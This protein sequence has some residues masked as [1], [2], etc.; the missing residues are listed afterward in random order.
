[1]PSSR[2]RWT[3]SPA[4]LGIGPRMKRRAFIKLLGGSVAAWPLAAGGQP[5]GKV[6]TVGVLMAGGENLTENAPRMTAFQKALA[7]LGWKDGENIR[8]I[9]RWSTGKREL[10][11]QYA[12]E[13]VAL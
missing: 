4:R 13:L 1:M 3:R 8:L 10:I 2:G 9:Y 6:P 12:K 5:T 11:D 7:E